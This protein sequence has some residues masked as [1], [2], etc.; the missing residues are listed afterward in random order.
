MRQAGNLL[1]KP[2]RRRSQK[3]GTET[4]MSKTLKLISLGAAKVLTRGQQS[5][6]KN[7]LDE[8]PYNPAG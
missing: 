4:S 8:R 5:G 7:E 2:P 1:G 3:T 6:T